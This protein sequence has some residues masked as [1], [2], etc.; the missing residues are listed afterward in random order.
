VTAAQGELSERELEI[1]ALIR[2]GYK[3]VEIAR[4][5]V[6][7][8][9]T[10]DTHV[11]HIY[12]KTGV[13]SRTGLVAAL[14]TAAAAAEMPDVGT[15][16]ISVDLSPALYRQLTEY[17]VTMARN[18]GVRRLPQAEIVRALIGVTGNDL[19]SGAVQSLLRARNAS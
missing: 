10:V 2:D 19:V 11:Q 7:S 6:L 4:Q 17:T 1:A 9:R 13:H 3:N 8:V 5:L 16:R 18:I 12:A 14:F 15:V